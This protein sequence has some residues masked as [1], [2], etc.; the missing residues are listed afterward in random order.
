MEIKNTTYF[1]TG[2]V[3]IV[4]GLS[5]IIFDYPQIMY[6]EQL[7]VESYTM[8]NFEEKSIHQR[9]LIEFT[10]GVAILSVGL[11]LAVLSVIKKQS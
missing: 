5:V 7:P 1:L 3:V 8:L 11:G 4:L 6:F 2:I 9:L 10:V